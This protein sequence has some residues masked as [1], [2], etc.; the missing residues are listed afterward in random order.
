MEEN[1]NK[2][3][4]EQISKEEEIGYHKGAIN[5]LV[6]ERNEMIKMIGNVDAIL[7]AHIQRLEQLGV[8]IRKE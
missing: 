1:L 8:K 4:N 3:V 7:Q 5:T 6:A 2:K